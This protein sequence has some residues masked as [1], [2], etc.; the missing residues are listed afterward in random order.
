MSAPILHYIYDPL[1]G[2]C[3]GAAPLLE[4][5]RSQGAV[6]IVLHGGGMMAGPN[7][8]P[9]SET[10]RR[11][12]MPHDYRIAA[13][14]GQVFGAD[15]FD[16]LL[17]DTSAM[18]DSEP[19]ITAILVAESLTP[20][21]GIDMLKRI[22]LAHYA[23]GQHI[24]D[25]DVLVHLAADLGF[26]AARFA[27]EFSHLNGSCTQAHIAASRNLLARVSGHGFPTFALEQQGE[28][29]LLDAGRYLGQPDA[30]QAYLLRQL[31]QW[32]SSGPSLLDEGP[33]CSEDGCAA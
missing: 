25:V 29:C 28:F 17:R 12:V 26:A 19:P 21:R 5:V 15:Y 14:T 33:V 24:A 9:V 30:W 11:Y 10:L 2:W 32:S 8:Q 16:G 3:Y 27:A 18:F 6:D 31:A 13:M 4:A 22:Q 23:E 7:R 1:C 20:G